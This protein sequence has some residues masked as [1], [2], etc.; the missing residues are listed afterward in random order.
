MGTEQM[1]LVTLNDKSPITNSR[2][3]GEVFGKDHNV[4]LR[5]IRDL[6]G[7]VAV[8][9]EKERLCNFAQSS[10]Y[11]PKI[12]LIPSSEEERLRKIAESSNLDSE[13][14][15]EFGEGAGKLISEPIRTYEPTA[16][17]LLVAKANAMDTERSK[18]ELDT[19]KCQFFRLT[20]YE[21]MTG[22]GTVREFPMY[23]MNEDGFALLV[24]GFTGVKAT[25]FKVRFIQEFNRLKHI[26]NQQLLLDSQKLHLIEDRSRWEDTEWRLQTLEAEK[27]AM[28]DRLTLLETKG[29]VTQL[30]SDIRRGGFR[31]AARIFY[32]PVRV[33][34][35][36]L[37]TA[38]RQTNIETM[39][40]AVFG[41]QDV[42][43]KAV[44]KTVDVTNNYD[45]DLEA[46]YDE[47]TV[48]KLDEQYS[49]KFAA[50][51]DANN[52]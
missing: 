44:D 14:R 49:A 47:E 37:A 45:L 25:M 39:R 5:A 41:V 22:N 38:A 33:A 40:R 23:E 52:F 43:H 48:A 9:V 20:T 11:Q 12:G 46:T 36:R 6:M 28:S 35:K 10:K 32:P 1:Q 50:K 21:V 34:L 30:R 7:D 51:L 31:D 16:Y 8:G 4:V 27:R 15:R 17:D 29:T 42:L 13:R 26:V 3:I 18:N 19:D 2:I 24:S